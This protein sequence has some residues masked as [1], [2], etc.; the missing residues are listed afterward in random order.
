MY[1]GTN[2]SLKTIL[3]KVMNNP[4]A[5]DL[6]YELAAEY[7]VEALRLV[8]APFVLEP[9]DPP[10]TINIVNYKGAMPLDIIE[11]TGL[12]G[13]IETEDETFYEVAL[14]YATDS[15]HQS[16]GCDSNCPTEATYTVNNGVI[17]T[18]FQTGRVQ[19]SYRA[20]PVDEDGF[21]LIPNN[22]KMILAVEYYILYKFL[23]PLW[24][25]GKISDKAFN[26]ISQQKHWYMGAAGSDLKLAGYDHIEAVMNTINRLIVD[27]DAH[28][29]F[30]RNSGQKERLK[31]FN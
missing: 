25:I 29:R 19:V 10:S 16:A 13:I 6:S 9:K 14:T 20:L 11:L 5:S 31:R 1:N 26:H 30:F 22:Q 21:P 3:W 4:L 2:V 28:R 15:F 12:K 23:E 17:K 8:G 18:S 24:I 7:A 27:S